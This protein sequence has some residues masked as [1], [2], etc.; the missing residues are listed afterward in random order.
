[1]DAGAIADTKRI[2]V[3]KEGKWD[4]IFNYE[5]GELPKDWKD[6]GQLVAWDAE[7]PF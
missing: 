2:L 1:M 6:P 7:I 5:V 3:G 4:R